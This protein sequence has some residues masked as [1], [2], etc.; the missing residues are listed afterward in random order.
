MRR[1][2]LQIDMDNVIVFFVFFLNC[3]RGFS[4]LAFVDEATHHVESMVQ[5]G[6]RCHDF[7]VK[8]RKPP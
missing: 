8:T 7:V 3:G 6:L 1:A 2:H 4:P 5:E